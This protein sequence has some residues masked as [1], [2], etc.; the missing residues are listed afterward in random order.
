MHLA[1]SVID[2]TVCQC[3]QYKSG[4]RQTFEN[5]SCTSTVL[6]RMIQRTKNLFVTKSGM[7]HAQVNQMGMQLAWRHPTTLMSLHLTQICFTTLHNSNWEE[8]IVLQVPYT[9]RR[10]YVQQMLDTY[11]NNF[12]SVG[13]RTTGT[14]EGYF[15]IVGPGWNSSLPPRT[16][17]D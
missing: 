11:N 1:Y 5:D 2:G 16:P 12:N 9:K 6:L 3:N 17:D 8:P 10:D 7:G 4:D 14:V 15:A 13:Q